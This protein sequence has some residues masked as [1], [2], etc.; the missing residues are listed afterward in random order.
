M[1]Q[2]GRGVLGS[3]LLF[4]TR[5][6]RVKQPLLTERW[7]PKW[8][9]KLTKKRDSV[10]RVSVMLDISCHFVIILEYFI[11]RISQPDLHGNYSTGT[12]HADP[13]GIFCR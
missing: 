12:C 10:G 9:Q 3:L 13:A 11:D 5:Q 6:K 2:L 4:G 1:L 7:P 8:P